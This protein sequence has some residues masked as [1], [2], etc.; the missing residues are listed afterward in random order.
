MGPG[1]TSVSAVPVGAIDDVGVG[2]GVAPVSGVTVGNT[3][4]VTVGMGV[5]VI[6][7]VGDAVGKRLMENI[8]V[9]PELNSGSLS[10]SVAKQLSLPSLFPHSIRSRLPSRTFEYSTS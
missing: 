3:D 9:S 6:V 8:L 10:V 5:G 7:G 4:G 1:V 2:L